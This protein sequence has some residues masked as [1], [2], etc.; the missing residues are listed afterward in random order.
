MAAFQPNVAVI[1]YLDKG[2]IYLDISKEEPFYE[3]NITHY[4]Q[5]LMKVFTYAFVIEEFSKLVIG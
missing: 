1:Q 2:F 4:P 3:A 5:L